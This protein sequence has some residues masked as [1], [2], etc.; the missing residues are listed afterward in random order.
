MKK[1]LLNQKPESF[2]CPFCQKWHI[3]NSTETLRQRTKNSKPLKCG[4]LSSKSGRFFNVYF[5]KD[6]L[7]YTFLSSCKKTT[8]KISGVVATSKLEHC[9][10]KNGAIDI[11][12]SIHVQTCN[13]PAQNCGKNKC[14]YCQNCYLH[15]E[16][17]E[18]FCD[19]LELCFG[20]EFK[21]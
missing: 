15:R 18:D 4:C 13:P 17:K 2:L 1:E 19:K 14:R 3:Y 9:K 20:F 5:L 6:N 10:I 12:T 11:T 8:P 21:P 7:H 16:N